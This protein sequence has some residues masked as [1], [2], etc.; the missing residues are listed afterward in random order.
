VPLL[1]PAGRIPKVCCFIW[2]ILEENSKMTAGVEDI[3][4]ISEKLTYG[5]GLV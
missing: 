5:N 4:A 3:L 2:C 1:C